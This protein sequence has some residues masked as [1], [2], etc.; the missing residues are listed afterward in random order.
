MIFL[1]A[2]DVSRLTKGNI[3]SI[4]DMFAALDGGKPEFS[5]GLL[6]LEGIVQ[7][8]S[9]RDNHRKPPLLMGH[10]LH[11]TKAAFA[12]EIWEKLFIIS[13][14]L[15]ETAYS[16][17]GGEWRC[18]FAQFPILQIFF[19]C[20][21]MRPSMKQITT[22]SGLSSGAVTQAVDLLVEDGLLERIPSEQDH[23][24][25]LVA[26]TARLLETRSKAV[27]HFETMLESFKKGADPEEMAVAEE[28]FTLLA[29]SRAGGVLAIMKQPSDLSRPGLVARNALHSECVKQLPVWLQMLHFT[30]NLRAPAIIYYYGKRGRMTLGKLRLLDHLFY[31][32][33]QEEMP[34]VKELASTFHVSSGVVS[35]T[36]NAMIRDGMVERVDSAWDRR[37]IRIRLTPLGLR[38]RRQTASTYTRFMQ[39]FFDAV[40]PEKAAVFDRMLD[41]TLEFLKNDGK[42]FLLHRNGPLELD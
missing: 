37:I 26:A 4:L 34:M 41:L 11:T 25:M 28:I 14:P 27:R 1:C 29:E 7:Q 13:S 23:R 9:P 35:Q 19:E 31:L 5:E 18:T 17:L 38:L 33:E 32:S 40:D 2:D 3:K 36:L 30:T 15:R 24:S 20:P 6:Y 10:P 21:E 8:P 12:R 39:N 42:A 22:A 16:L